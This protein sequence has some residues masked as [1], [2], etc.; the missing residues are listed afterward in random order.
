[1]QQ[2]LADDGAV[3][4]ELRM[5]MAL[6]ALDDDEIDR[7]QLRQNIPKRRLGFLTQFM[8]DGPTPA[9]NDRDLAGAGL[10]VQP[11][12]LARLVGIEFM[13][14]VLDGRYFQAALDQHRDH[15]GDQRCLAGA[16]PARETDDAHCR[17]KRPFGR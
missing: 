14:R 2:R 10:A 8:H 9:G 4:F 5:R 12:I 13:M 17:T 3:D 16:A 11:R 15:I 1:M 7:A 6:E